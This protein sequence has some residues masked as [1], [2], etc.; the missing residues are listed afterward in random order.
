MEKPVFLS[1][2]FNEDA[3]EQLKGLIVEVIHQLRRLTIVDGKTLDLEDS[4]SKTITDFIKDQSACLIAVFTN[5]NHKNSNVLYELG[6]AVGSGKRVIIVAEN[7]GVVPTMLRMHPVITPKSKLAWF[8]DFQ[9]ELEKKLRSIF[10]LPED[11]FIENKLRRRYSTEERR[12]MK[13]IQPLE[14]PMSC[15]RAGDLRKAETILTRHLRED[16][17]DL[18]SMFLLSEAYYL[19]GCSTE[20]PQEREMFFRK[21]LSLTLQGLNINPG[22]VLCLSS[23]AA[24]HMRL[25]EFELAQEHLDKLLSLDSG[26]SV[27]HYNAAC[28]A[29]LTDNK[30]KTLQHL[31]AAIAINPE[32]KSFAKEDPDFT[33]YFHDVEWQELVY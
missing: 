15:I 26:F 5:G 23:R 7:I 11:H 22:H 28:L 10:Q 2:K 6:V 18:D 19:N 4:F 25:G 31:S 16:P 33:S 21:Q 24:A 8:K 1:Y 12:H 27:A 3:A 20:D 29:A 30:S 32:W 9:A 17:G 14:L 13:N